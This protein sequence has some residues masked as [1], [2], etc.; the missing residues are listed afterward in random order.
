ML[1]RRLPDTRNPIFRAGRADDE[2]AVRVGE[3]FVIGGTTFTVNEDGIRLDVEAPPGAT[4]QAFSPAYLQSL[5]FH[6]A[7]ERIEILSHLPEV[8]Q[9]AASDDELFVRLIGLL[10]AGIPRA[11]SAAIVACEPQRAAGRQVRVLQWDRRSSEAATFCPS[12]RLICHAVDSEAS[13]VNVWPRSKQARTNE[14]THAENVDWAFCT[15][16]SVNACRGWALYLEGQFPADAVA[17]GQVGP[18]QLQDDLKFTELAAATLRSLRE[19]RLLEQRQA[20]L[21]Q[22]FSPIVLEALSGSDPDDV[23]VP[24]ETQVAVLF[25]DLRGFSRRSERDSDN[26]MG[27]LQRVS[28]ALGV[29]TSHI[30]EQG[31]VI[32]D[33]HGD[34]AMGFWGWPLEQPDAVQRA[35]RAALLI[36]REFE[37]AGRRDEH[38]LVDFR[39]GIGLTTG[40]AVAG[41]IGTA[42]QVKVTVF[43]PVVNLAARL[44]SMTKILRAPI[45]IDQT[46]ARCIRQT[47]TLDQARV[48]RVAK[49]RPAGMSNAVEVSELLPPFREFPQVADQHIQAY[50]AALDALL[51]RDLDTAFQLLHQV[52][53]DDRVK[54]FLTVFIAQ[55]H[56]TPPPDWDG[57]IPVSAWR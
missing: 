53:A 50:E 35:A 16:V 51:A 7:D 18:E 31:G 21:R 42:D 29:M 26:L 33:F 8:I 2:F 38:S 44:E 49:V 3:H 22:F 17:R 5:R 20:G 39:I 56:R 11:T 47:M 4:E 19:I 34:A 23:L 43:G 40:N 46:T 12:S 28:D 27:L 14:F 37:Q 6:D 41:K 57:V 48:R 10:L 15:P 30:L 36:R 54:D 52:P 55:H 13:V 45:L 25:C 32:G 9:G 24:R 1:V